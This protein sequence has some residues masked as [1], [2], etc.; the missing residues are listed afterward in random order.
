MSKLIHDWTPS[1]AAI[2]LIKLNGVTDEQIKK[3]EEYLKSQ[4][5]LKSVDD[6]SGYD[7]WDS[8]F[9]IFCIKANRKLEK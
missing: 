1:E 9:I 6:L 8:F 5:E 7:N 3:S 2:D 4:G